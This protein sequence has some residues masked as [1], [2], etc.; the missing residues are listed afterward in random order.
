MND[1]EQMMNGPRI[2]GWEPLIKSN[3]RQCQLILLAVLNRGM[4][5]RKK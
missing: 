1:W 2:S 4:L 3:N 5:A